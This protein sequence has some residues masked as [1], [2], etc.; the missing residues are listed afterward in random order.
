ML[1]CSRNSRCGLL[2]ISAN[3][4]RSSGWKMMTRA[5]ANSA[6]TLLSIQAKTSKLSCCARN[7]PTNVTT[8]MPMRMNAARVPLRNTSAM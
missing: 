1:W 3:V 4:R 2:P 7:Q 6:G 5:K 8:T